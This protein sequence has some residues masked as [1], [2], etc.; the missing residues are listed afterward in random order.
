ME[1]MK[2]TR[3]KAIV[4]KIIIIDFGRFELYWFIEFDGD[5]TIYLHTDIAYNVVS[6]DRIDSRS[7]FFFPMSKQNNYKCDWTNLYSFLLLICMWIEYL[8]KAENNSTCPDVKFQ[9]VEL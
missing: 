8:I 7:M 1:P 4:F 6:I 5:F 2:M 9:N 3:E